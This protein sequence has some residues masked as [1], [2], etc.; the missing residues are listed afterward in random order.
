MEGEEEACGACGYGVLLSRQGCWG[1]R[2]G[3]MRYI[4]H[5]GI[6]LQSNELAFWVD[7]G[8]ATSLEAGL[9]FYCISKLIAT[10]TVVLGKSLSYKL[11]RIAGLLAIKSAQA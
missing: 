1:E 7:M 8:L 5:E 4:M 6:K 11:D 3:S 9:C 10:A 2:E